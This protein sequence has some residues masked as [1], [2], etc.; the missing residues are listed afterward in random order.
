MAGGIQIWTIYA[1]AKVRSREMNPKIIN[2][3]QILWNVTPFFFLSHT[4]KVLTQC[5]T[6]EYCST[7]LNLL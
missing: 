2:S 5:F 1:C 4:Q 6:Y 3:A 7:S